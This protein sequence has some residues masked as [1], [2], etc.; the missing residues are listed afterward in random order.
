ML[1]LK[2]EGAEYYDYVMNYV[3]D[4]IFVS[5]D[6]V[7]K[8]EKIAQFTRI[9]N[10]NIEPPSDLLRAVLVKKTVDGVNLW[11][12]PSQKF[13]KDVLDYAVEVTRSKPYLVP[14]KALT[15][16]VK[17]LDLRGMLLKSWTTT[18]FITTIS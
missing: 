16:M 12:I 14:F 17:C 1:D 18:V 15:P 7:G 5:I 13:F 9:N 11:T 3:D 6:A 4:I 8:L 10:G 2:S